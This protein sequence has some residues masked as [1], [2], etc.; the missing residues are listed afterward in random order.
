[1]EV[2]PMRKLAEHA[3]RCALL[4]LTPV[5]VL[6]QTYT[7][8]PLAYG[9]V[10]NGTTNDTAAFQ[11]CVNDAN[12]A[13]GGVCMIPSTVSHACV[14]ATQ[15]VMD[16]FSGVALAG[17]PAGNT[18]L[19]SSAN[20]KLLF[21][22]TP[23]SLISMRSTFGVAIKNLTLQYNNAS[24]SGSVLDLSHGAS[25]TDSDMDYIADC[26]IEGTSS[27]H[28]GAL[29]NLDKTINVTLERNIYEWAVN[30]IVGSATTSSYSNV[31]RIR[32][33]LFGLY[34]T[35]SI[36]G[37]MI[38][39]LGTAWTIEGNTFE[40]YDAAAS[41]PIA[42]NANSVPCQGG[43][44]I[45]GNWIGD[46]HSGYTGA[47]ITGNFSGTSISGNYIDGV[48]GSSVTGVLLASISNGVSI[49]GNFFGSLNTAVEYLD[50]AAT[51]V[52]VSGNEYLGVIN[53]ASGAPATGSIESAYG[54]QQVFYGNVN[55][56]GT[57]SKT[58]GAFKINHPLDPQHKYL[59]HSFVESPDMMNVYNGIAKLN[60][61]GEAE[62]RLPSYFQAL[63]KDFRYQLTS[64]GRFAPVYVKRTIHDN[65]FR[66]A[67]GK[68]GG[69]VSWQVTGIRHDA[70][71]DAH[72]IV[73][74]ENQPSN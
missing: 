74:E 9:A 55:V 12:A 70:Y 32:D 68:A 64:I 49:T 6:A 7:Y 34:N 61:Q 37:N 11:T 10:C 8:N 20:P 47:L 5:T 63:N 51:N 65:S 17:P 13:G 29:V 72:R 14:I 1:M 33:S 30:G 54:Y 62:V 31:V 52:S 38:L 36:S 41:Y 40:M 21:T 43:C 53:V 66:I 39:N 46:V 48:G 73:V 16:G 67:G 57:L 18:G 26:T 4:L 24:F 59:E 15:I 60:A 58:A 42:V 23:S 69:E 45:T 25:G 3:L 56:Q 27:A 71:A 2:S 35:D 44:S 28:S 19:S 22:G 50:N